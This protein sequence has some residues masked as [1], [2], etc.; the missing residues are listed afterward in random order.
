MQDPSLSVPPPSVHMHRERWQEH[1]DFAPQDDPQQVVPSVERLGH[2][3]SAAGHSNRQTSEYQPQTWSWP[4]PPHD[5][6]Y[7]SSL[8]PISNVDPRSFRLGVNE[9]TDMDEG[10]S[11]TGSGNGGT[12][13][14]D[15]E[16]QTWP[17]ST[18]ENHDTAVQSSNSGALYFHPIPSD[19]TLEC[20]ALYSDYAGRASQ[21]TSHNPYS[22]PSSHDNQRQND[23]EY[24]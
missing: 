9:N 13:H 23:Y 12:R 22:Y 15:G 19:Y 4:P 10:A 1:Y 21:S 6:A 14:I 18:N 11:L 2:G 16:T 5:S 24:E 8:P 17:L 20:D 3:H 7:Y